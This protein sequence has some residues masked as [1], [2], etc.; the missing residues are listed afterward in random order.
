MHDTPD[1]FLTEEEIITDMMLYRLPERE[2]Q[3]LRSVAPKELKD[4]CGELSAA[5]IEHYRLNDENNPYTSSDM[6]ADNTAVSVSYRIIEKIWSRLSG[7]S[8]AL[9]AEYTKVPEEVTDYGAL[10]WGGP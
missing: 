10:N 7:K 9:L 4:L 1:M 2:K 6:L 8:L 3:S 5:L